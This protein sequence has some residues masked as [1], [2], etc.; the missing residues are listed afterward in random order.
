MNS[1]KTQIRVSAPNSVFKIEML[2]PESF[3]DGTGPLCG[4]TISTD[5]WVKMQAMAAS[6]L[7]EEISRVVTSRVVRFW[8]SILAGTVPYGLHVTSPDPITNMR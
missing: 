1:D 2:N 6:F 5:E 3:G 8:E 4:S 7:N